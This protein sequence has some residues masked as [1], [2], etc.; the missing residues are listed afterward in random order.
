VGATTPSAVLETHMDPADPVA[1]L[2]DH[3]LLNEFDDAAFLDVVGSRLRLAR[4]WWRP[5]ATRWRDRCAG[6]GWWRAEPLAGAYAYSGSGVPA[7]PAR[8]SRA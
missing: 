6:S 2:G 1:F 3:L 7:S 4:S 5:T 8:Q